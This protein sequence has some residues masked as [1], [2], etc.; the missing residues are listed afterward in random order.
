MNACLCACVCVNIIICAQILKLT[1]VVIL[2]SFASSSS[3]LF[4]FSSLSILLKH[5]ASIYFHMQCFSV[6]PACIP[7]IHVGSVYVSLWVLHAC[8]YMSSQQKRFEC[9]LVSLVRSF[10]HTKD[11]QWILHKNKDSTLHI[12]TQNIKG[13]AM[14]TMVAEIQPKKITYTLTLVSS[15]IIIHTQFDCIGNGVAMYTLCLW[16]YLSSTRSL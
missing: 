3:F 16:V 14:H 9:V 8:W 15:C 11:L 1:V 10:T 4:Y 13:Y 2:P 6:C 5:D 7:C 12:H